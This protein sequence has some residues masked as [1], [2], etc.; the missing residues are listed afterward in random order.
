MKTTKEKFLQKPYDDIIDDLNLDEMQKSET[1]KIA[2]GLFHFTFWSILI[3]SLAMLIFGSIN[4]T[5]HLLCISSILLLILDMGIYIVFAV[6]TS[7]KGIMNQKFASKAGN[8]KTVIWY[9][10]LAVIYIDIFKEDVY[11]SA[12]FGIVYITMCIIA[13][14]AARNNKVLEKL[15]SDD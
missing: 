4:E 8:K 12:Y 9:L 13:V 10:I 6:R 11:F 7:S 1:Y 5:S 14:M 15:S 2:F 3:F